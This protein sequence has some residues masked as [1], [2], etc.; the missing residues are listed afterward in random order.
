MKT[1]ETKTD[2]KTIAEWKEHWQ[3]EA[4]ASYLYRILAEI[5]TDPKKRDVFARL[6]DVEDRHTSMWAKVIADH[7]AQAPSRVKPSIRTRI[8]ARVAKRFGPS[9]LISLMLREEGQEVKGYLRLHR[10]SE[11]Q[12]AKQTALTLAH[13]SAEHAEDLAKLA[14]DEESGEPWH[15][16]GSGG[17]LR[18]VVYGFNDGLTANFGLVAGVIGATAAAGQAHAV[19][20]AGIAGM[21]A[22]ALSMGSS[23]YLAAKSEQEVHDHEIA[24]EK[25]EI[26]LMPEVEEEELALIYEMK[27]VGREQARELAKDVM[28]SPA[29]ALE[30]KVREELKIG[31]PHATP[32]REGW[33]TGTATAIGAFIPVFPFLVFSGALSIGLAFGIA[34]VS[35]FG[36]GAARSF[37]TGR[38]IFRSGFDM[39]VVGLGVAAVGYFVGESLVR[40]L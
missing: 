37:F 12:A 20:V 15:R 18:N 23:G 36:V 25:Q 19:L 29:R 1:D 9:M 4:E 39:F 17:F 16:T 2:A 21:V 32:F 33:I 8:L 40:I 31:E 34:M 13:E 35:H 22:D 10:D 26:E 3:D 27:G 30:E 7:G 24:V 38:G 6:A 5:E 28:M 14:G 11:L